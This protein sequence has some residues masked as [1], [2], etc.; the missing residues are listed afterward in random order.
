MHLTWG[1]TL[2]TQIHVFSERRKELT[3]GHMKKPD[4]YQEQDISAK[5]NSRFRLHLSLRR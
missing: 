2:T 5:T 4:I 1:D 3:E